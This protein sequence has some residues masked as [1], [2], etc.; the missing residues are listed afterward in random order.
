MT[1]REGSNLLENGTRRI[2]CLVVSISFVRLFTFFLHKQQSEE[3]KN[4]LQGETYSLGNTRFLVI[5]YQT[6]IPEIF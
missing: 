4:K 5:N 2:S 3:R 1:I 6:R